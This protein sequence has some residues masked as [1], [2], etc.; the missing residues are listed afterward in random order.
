MTYTSEHARWYDA[1]GYATLFSADRPV[2]AFRAQKLINNVN[3]IRDVSTQTRILQ[4]AKVGETVATTTVG[5]NIW[6][7]WRQYQIPWTALGPRTFAKA[8]VRVGGFIASGGTDGTAYLRFGMFPLG[9]RL[10]Q[11]NALAWYGETSFSNTTSSV[12]VSTSIDVTWMPTFT[13]VES[14][15]G[16]KRRR[17]DAV[18]PDTRMGLVGYDPQSDGTFAPSVVDVGALNFVLFVRG[19]SIA[20]EETVSL[21]LLE[22]R[23]YG[24]GSP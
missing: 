13:R 8:I 12:I 21:T 9:Y 1:E 10:S 3:H 2:S 11:P 15:S 22:L 14:V 18:N 24:G 20:A 4:V 5:S 6:S 7:V 17:S 16:A 23:E 19:N